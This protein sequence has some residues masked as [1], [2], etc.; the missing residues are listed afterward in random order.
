MP[1]NYYSSQRQE[2]HQFLPTSFSR[3]LDVGCGEGAYGAAVQSKHPGVEI[4]GVEPY[5]PAATIAASRLTHVFNDSFHDQLSIPDDYFDV[6]T[7]NDSLEHMAEEYSML[8]L[9]HKKLTSNGVLICSV[10]NIRYLEVVRQLLFDAD[11]K[12]TDSGV[13]DRTHLRFFTRKSICRAISSTA[14]EI[15]MVKGINSHWWS[16]WKVALLR[17]IFQSKIEDMRW[18]QFVVV[19]TR[20]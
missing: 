15:Q 9:A 10:P 14:F 4:W 11:W 12:Y 3:L 1:S 16:G 5:T 2:L 20:K 18:Q 17:L 8:R 13:L 19:A 7:F 6:V